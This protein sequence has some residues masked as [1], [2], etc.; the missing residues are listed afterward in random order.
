[1]YVMECVV[2]LA[3][4]VMVVT[5]ACKKGKKEGEATS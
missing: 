2:L 5:I 1:M 3:I 4:I